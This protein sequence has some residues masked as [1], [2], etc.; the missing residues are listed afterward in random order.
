VV[1]D[2]RDTTTRAK[3][4]G[5]H[6]TTV[7]HPDIKLVRRRHPLSVML[8]ERMKFTPLLK[9]LRSGAEGRFSGACLRPRKLAGRDETPNLFLTPEATDR[10]PRRAI[11]QAIA[12][13]V[14]RPRTRP[15][16]GASRGTPSIEAN[17]HDATPA[18]FDRHMPNIAHVYPR[19]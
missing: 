3:R 16:R 18:P 6:D 7:A 5:S 2:D 8:R 14:I 15:E 9:Q 19:P 17:R 13:A 4:R 12:A 1:P 10:T 11:G